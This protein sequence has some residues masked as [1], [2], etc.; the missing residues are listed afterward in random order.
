MPNI[1]IIDIDNPYSVQ[2][3]LYS[4]EAN[5]KHFVNVAFQREGNIIDVTNGYTITA[6]LVCD[7]I[8]IVQDVA[9]NETTIQGTPCAQL[10]IAP[11]D[12]SFTV[13][14][15]RL[16]I[17]FALTNTSDNSVIHPVAPL[18]VRVMPAP[19]EHAQ[20]NVNSLGSYAE[21][22]REIADA[23]GDETTLGDRIDRIDG[24]V[25]TLSNGQLPDGRYMLFA[26][27]GAVGTDLIANG[28]VNTSK[29]T[30]GAVTS[31]KLAAN[32][33]TT[34]KIV[35]SAVTEAKLDDNS[36][37]R[38]KI[39]DAAVNG[40]KISN[41]SITG[42]KIVPGEIDTAQ[43]KNGAVT[44][45]K[46]AQNT[47]DSTHM[48]QTF[49]AMSNNSAQ[50][51]AFA[52]NTT[53]PTT[54]LVKA[55]ILDQIGDGA[56]GEAQLATDAVTTAKIKDKAVTPEK[57]NLVLR[58][59]LTKLTDMLEWYNQTDIITQVDEGT[60][61]NPS[62]FNTWLSNT[63]IFDFIA[64]GEVAGRFN[65]PHDTAAQLKFIGD[66]QVV[67]FAVYNKRYY[68]H[69]DSYAPTFIAGAWTLAV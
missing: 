16:Q 43:L 39:K 38:G 41:Y 22:V 69:I 40:A 65:V 53:T 2:T 50:A 26:E 10:N 33:V 30:N 66:Y 44:G 58:N 21:V 63:T 46:V 7:N 59:L 36:V 4:H 34:E 45:A 37:T 23:R 15:G 11:A 55:W 1:L 48:S 64:S 31:E 12:G 5:V 32:S 29:L 3:I 51:W 8:L 13:P 67:T 17:D 20:I 60:V 35:D 6:D 9:V 68:R 49:L 28:A 56:V 27:Y 25:A 54:A 42:D 19:A 47:L 61:T 52:N 18:I 62:T 14:A 24:D 57:L